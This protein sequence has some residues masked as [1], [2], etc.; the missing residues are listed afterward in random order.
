[1]AGG[2]EDL[3]ERLPETE[4][5]VADGEL[6]SD[7]KAAGLQL[8]QEL[9]P[10]LGALPPPHMEAEEVLPASGV[11]PMMTR[12]HSASGSIR[13]SAQRA[14]ALQAIEAV[15]ATLLYPP[16]YSL[17]FTTRSKCPSPSS[18]SCSEP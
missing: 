17:D 14:G 7:G 5:A 11:A 10:A 16:P 1:M 3:L 9:A 13:E 12:M 15:G 8:D 6:G 18:R 4:G 2:R